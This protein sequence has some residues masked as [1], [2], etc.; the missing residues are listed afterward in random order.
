MFIDSS[1]NAAEYAD[2]GPFKVHRARIIT[3]ELTHITL[4]HKLIVLEALWEKI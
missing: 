3:H 1:I 2:A 4:H